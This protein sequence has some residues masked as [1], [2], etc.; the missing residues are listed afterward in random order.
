MALADLDQAT[1]LAPK[2]AYLALWL[3]I[4]NK[5]SGLQSRLAEAMKQIDMTRWPAPTI[6][7]YLG[8]MTPEAVL[9][10]A[11]SPD[12][13]TRKRQVCDADFFIGELDLQEGKKD[14][15][16]R[17]FRSATAGC[18]EFLI[19]YEGA[20]AELKALGQRPD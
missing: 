20:N 1:E 13:D 7:L 15:A 12:A 14:D 2:D 17:L 3:D 8:Q 11:D 6:R 19:A 16:T 4:A 18:P 5:R 10:A 9:A